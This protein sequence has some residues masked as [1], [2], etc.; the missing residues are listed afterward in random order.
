MSPPTRRTMLTLRDRHEVGRGVEQFEFVGADPSLAL[1]G[2]TPGAHLAL[3]TPVRSNAYSLLDD[4]YRPDAYRIAVR[5]AAGDGG[6]DWLHRALRPGDVI[7]AA[8]P[9][10][11]FAPQLAA[12]N[13]LLIAAGIGVTP[14]LSHARAARRWG[15]R[16]ELIVGVS[17]GDPL[18]RRELDAVAAG[19][20]RRVE[21]RTALLG[22]VRDALARQPLGTH[23]YVCGRTGFFTTVIE[24]ARALG[25]PDERMHVEAFDA[26]EL[27]GGMP[28]RAVIRSTGES[29][30][31]PSGVSLLQALDQRGIVLDRLC[32]RGVCGRCLVGVR[33]GAV[34]HRD[35]V[36]SAAERRRDDRML[37]CVSRAAPA[38]SPA[39]PATEPSA[40]PPAEPR[41]ELEL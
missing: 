1:P 30:E 13:H 35:L 29:I 26:P 33:S 16:F 41:L 14:M 11:A 15:R 37:A 18:F 25:W 17:R 2:Y 22:A 27:D 24:E 9:R 32:E 8:P 34:L 38:E 31:V 39:E 5:R 28:F 7:E 19:R 23:A 10:S 36:L 4:G 21:G 40:H 6:S 12:S 3:R 20:L